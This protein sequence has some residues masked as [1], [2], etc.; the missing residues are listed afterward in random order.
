MYKHDLALNSLQGLIY[1]KIHRGNQDIDGEGNFNRPQYN[2][3][4]I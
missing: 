3:F 2:P 1:H 4:S